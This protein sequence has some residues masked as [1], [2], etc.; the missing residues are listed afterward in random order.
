MSDPLVLAF[1]SRLSFPAKALRTAQER[2]T[3]EQLA[4]EMM[5]EIANPL[6]ALGHFTYL[7]LDEAD[8]AEEVRTYLRLA[9]EQLIIL[10]YVTSQTPELA[11]TTRSPKPTNLV[12]LVNAALRIHQRTINSKEVN[13]HQNLCMDA[14]V[15]VCRGKTLQIIS[16]LIANALDALPV[17]GTLYLG[18]SRN[19]SK[20]HL[21]VA[22]NGS[23]ISSQSVAHIFGP[24]FM[25]KGEHGTGLGLG[26]SKTIVE[27]YQGSIRV[28][29]NTEPGKSSTVF[30]IPFLNQLH[31]CVTIHEVAP[32]LS[33]SNLSQLL[34]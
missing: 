30:K 26:I 21:T 18:L 14:I 17:E 24:F 27:R 8:N 15:E 4:L 32:I 16:N 33:T 10:H 23:G 11:N 1:A 3:A 25:T 2:A 13:L 6:E 5:H 22:D 28:R 7:A 34:L 20:I 9:E 31:D 19:Q 12:V 29:S